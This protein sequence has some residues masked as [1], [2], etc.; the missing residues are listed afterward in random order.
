ML[1]ISQSNNLKKSEQ[2]RD[3]AIIA[4]VTGQGMEKLFRSVGV[5]SIISGG[6]TM[7]PSTEDI[8]KAVNQSHAKQALVLPNNKNIF[9]AAEQ[10]E[11]LTDIP[12]KVVHTKTIPQGLTAM[13]SLNPEASLVTNQ[14]NMDSS[15]EMVKSGQLTAAVR[16]TQIN[17][18]DIKKVSTWALLMVKSKLSLMSSMLPLLKQLK[19]CWMLIVRM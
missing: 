8:V 2:P 6:Q 18:F 5:T 9:L 19:R 14:K 17:G 11:K 1:L 13:F 3:L 10:A 15:L 4:I 7:N 16:D 12:M